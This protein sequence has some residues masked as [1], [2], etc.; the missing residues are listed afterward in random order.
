MQQTIRINRSASDRLVKI[1]S[2][3][4][5]FVQLDGVAFKET[6]LHEGLDSTLTLLEPSFRGRIN[7]IKE[8][9]SIPKIPCFPSELNQ[10]FMNLLLNAGQA[11]ENKGTITIKTFAQ[12]DWVYVQISDTGVGIPPERMKHLFEP[13]FTKKELRVKAG[14]GLFIGYNIV[15][16]HQGELKVE[17]KVGKGSIFT[18]SLPANFKK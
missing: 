6:D 11:I 16:K 8:Y 13:A 5:S 14:I 15:Q 7:V 18:I 3:L 4:K 12:E 10:V 9:S 17:S 1:I 2:S